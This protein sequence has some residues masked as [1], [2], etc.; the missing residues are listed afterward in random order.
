MSDVRADVKIGSKWMTA[1]MNLYFYDKAI[2]APEIKSAKIPIPGTSHTINLTSA[3]SGDVEYNERT[4]TLKLISVADK[5]EYYNV[6]SELENYLHGQTF[7]IIFNVDP[8]YYWV[9]EVAVTN[10]ERTWYGQIFT[11]TCTVDPYKYETHTDLAVHNYNNIPVPEIT[12]VGVQYSS[13]IQDT[14]WQTPVTNGEIS[15]TV[16]LGLRLE[17]IKIELIGLSSDLYS[18]NYRIHIQDEGWQAWHKDG[19]VAGTI[20][21]AL[22]AEAI[23]IAVT[24][25]DDVV[26]IENI[27]KVPFGVIYTAQI[28]NIG[29]QEPA[30][31]GY[32]SGT[33]GESLRMEAM[34]IYISTKVKIYGIRKRISPIMDCSAAMIVTDMERGYYLNAGINQVSGIFLG[35]GEHTLSFAKPGIV[36]IDYRGGSL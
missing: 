4:I 12:T 13:Y 29:W 22:R 20:G 7:Q 36:S 34:R 8:D 14:G 3:L 35:A 5:D 26:T 33:T 25:K 19:E 31:D 1:D 28:E 15:G 6:Q 30:S 18:V 2:S 21:E 9:G 11:L 10:I 16:G 24:L 23:Q 32:L 17:A 27:A